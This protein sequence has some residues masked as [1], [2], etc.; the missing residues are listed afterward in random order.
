MSSYMVAY[1]YTKRRA[2]LR[3]ESKVSELITKLEGERN[4]LQEKIERAEKKEVEVLAQVGRPH[5]HTSAYVAPVLLLAPFFDV[6]QTGKITA[7][8]D[9]GNNEKM[10]PIWF[11]YYG[12]P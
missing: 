10:H 12:G 1:Q 9:D 7:E 11:Y 4:E 8:T 5:K 3:P 2:R 6:F